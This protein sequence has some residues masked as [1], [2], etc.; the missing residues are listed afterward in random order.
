MSDF[1]IRYTAGELAT[2]S[3]L[4]ELVKSVANLQDGN[5]LVWIKEFET[6]VLKKITDTKLTGGNEVMDPQITNMAKSIVEVVTQMASH[7]SE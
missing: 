7:K 1:N 4:Q 5:A 3:I 2:V 6:T